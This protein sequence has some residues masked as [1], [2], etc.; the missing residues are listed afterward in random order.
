MIHQFLIIITC[1]I[2]VNHEKSDK[3]SMF[4]SFLKQDK[5]N[6]L[7]YLPTYIT[8][9]NL[10]AGMS[11]SHLL[12]HFLLCHLFCH[13]TTNVSYITCICWHVVLFTH[14]IDLVNGLRCNG[15]CLLVTCQLELT[16]LLVTCQ[17]ELTVLWSG[18]W[19]TVSIG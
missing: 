9:Y 10:F 4:C 15:A 16:C 5:L 1:N 8:R 6:I 13:K 2:M 14:C 3:L 18:C 17:L 12:N 19:H 11:F 7:N